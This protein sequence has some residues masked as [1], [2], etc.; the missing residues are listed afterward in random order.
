MSFFAVVFTISILF[1]PFYNP[2]YFYLQHVS[3]FLFMAMFIYYLLKLG[4]DRLENRITKKTALKGYTITV[5]VLLLF[6]FSN[7]QLY[8]IETYQ[9]SE[10]QTCSYYDVYGNAIY[11]SQLPNQCPNLEI[12]NQDDATLSFVVYEDISGV[13][14]RGYMNLDFDKEYNLEAKMRSDI[15]ITYFDDGLIQS[16]DT[17]RSVNIILSN[18]IEEYK[19]Y[20]SMQTIIENTIGTSTPNG[21]V[22]SYS[23]NIT[24]K[25]L[26]DQFYDFQRLDDVTH[27][28]GNDFVI[29]YYGYSSV[30]IFFGNGII[31][32]GETNTD[33]LLTYQIIVKEHH[34]TNNTFTE[35]TES[36]YQ[37]NDVRCGTDWCHID[38]GKWSGLTTASIPPVYGNSIDYYMQLYPNGISLDYE[39]Y[40]YTESDMGRTITIY[41]DFDD[42]GFVFE[43]EHNTFEN[44]LNQGVDRRTFTY[45][46]KQYIEH[47]DYYSIFHE[48]SY[49]LKIIRKYAVMDGNE[50]YRDF[51]N[52]YVG[53]DW[54]TDRMDS[55]L[56]YGHHRVLFINDYGSRLF[57]QLGARSID[58]IYQRNPLIFTLVEYKE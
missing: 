41:K 51:P 27:Y 24:L 47:G 15:Q 18:D 45:L 35:G 43:S 29:D 21:I 57:D 37:V 54:S 48:T 53:S 4:Y 6:L 36:I 20:N 40:R 46:G 3:L 11:Y 30:P 25:I 22:P 1:L 49:G 7:I 56:H 13:A 26:E 44:V 17:K 14:E 12:V 5:F 50:P 39:Y 31:I 28:V 42:Y 58:I 34:F 8:A 19:V 52:V 38:S 32:D 23:S 10:Y 55:G 33:N 2:I 9:T 16:V